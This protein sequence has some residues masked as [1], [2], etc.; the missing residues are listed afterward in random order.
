[1]GSETMGLTVLLKEPPYFPRLLVFFVVVWHVFAY[2]VLPQCHITV[3]W[4]AAGAPRVS[5]CQHTQP[6]QK[7]APGGVLGPFGGNPAKPGASAAQPNFTTLHCGGPL[8]QPRFGAF[9]GLF[10]LV[11]PVSAKTATFWPRSHQSARL[12]AQCDGT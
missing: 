7:K 8:R 2:Q 1:M 3:P 5:G 4:A 11:R 12:T 9:W 6:A 10:L